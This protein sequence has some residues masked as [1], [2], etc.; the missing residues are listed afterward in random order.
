MRDNLKLRIRVVNRTSCPLTHGDI[1]TARTTTPHLN[2]AFQS[3]VGAHESQSPFF[4]ASTVR[5][6]DLTAIRYSLE[7]LKAELCVQF[8]VDFDVDRESVLAARVYVGRMD[9]DVRGPEH[10]ERI[11]EDMVRQGPASAHPRAEL[12]L[13]PFT[14]T[15]EARMNPEVWPVLDIVV[16]CDVASGLSTSQAE[17]SALRSIIDSEE[18]TLRDDPSSSAGIGWA[19]TSRQRIKE[20]GV[21]GKGLFISSKQEAFEYCQRLKRNKRMRKKIRPRSNS[22]NCSA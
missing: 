19:L 14:Y 6:S 8:K 10:L 4:F 7:P 5:A 3:H 21:N 11:E 15:V 18:S 16:E 12:K 1:L 20:Q 13:G 9:G 17:I 22:P 2:F